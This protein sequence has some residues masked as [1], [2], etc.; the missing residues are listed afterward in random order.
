MK[1]I[2]YLFFIFAFVTLAFGSLKD[3]LGGLTMYQAGDGGFV[4]QQLR[5]SALQLA[6]GNIESTKSGVFLATVFNQIEKLTLHT[7]G[8]FIK[9]NTRKDGGFSD[10]SET[11]D[12]SSTRDILLIYNFLGIKVQN[13]QEILG[14]VRSLY[15]EKSGLY[16]N[17]V[18]E[19]GSLEATVSAFQVFNLLSTLKSSFVT[20]NF[21]RIQAILKEALTTVDR[22]TFFSFQ[23]KDLPAITANSYAAYLAVITELDITEHIEGLVNYFISLQKP[24]GG[25][26]SGDDSG[27]YKNTHEAIYAIALLSSV[28]KVDYITQRV[29]LEALQEFIESVGTSLTDVSYAQQTS[30]AAGLI[31]QHFNTEL[32]LENEQGDVITGGLTV[33]TRFRPTLRI[34]GYNGLASNRFT[35]EINTL[36]GANKEKFQLNYSKEKSKYI[37]IDIFDTRKDL[38]E[39]KFQVISRY[40]VANIGIIGLDFGASRTVGYKL[41]ISPKAYQESAGK[42][43]NVGE[44]VSVGTSFT[45]EVSLD[46]EK[47][48]E[49]FAAQMSVVDS[50]GAV[51]QVEE[52][53]TETDSVTFRFNLEKEN[54]PSGSLSFHFVVSNDKV[55]AHSRG[56]VVYQVSSKM[57]ASE[58]TFLGA[59]RKSVYK[60]GDRVDVRMVPASFD[61]RSV[62]LLDNTDFLGKNIS[63]E[64]FMDVVAGG[65]TVHSIR[66]H[67]TTEGYLFSLS[68][69]PKLDNFGHNTISFRYVTSTGESIELSPYDSE[70]NDL[71]DDVNQLS[72]SVPSDLRLFELTEEPKTTTLSY[73]NNVEFRFKLRD[74]N[75]GQI[76]KAGTGGSNV[77]LSLV[78]KDES[79]GNT[80]TS[81][82]KSATQSGDSFEIDWAITPNAISGPAE[83]VIYAQGINNQRLE[84]LS[85]KG[86]AVSYKVEIGGKID[87]SQNVYSSSTPEA[88]KTTVVATFSLS[89]Q[90]VDLRDALLYASFQTSDGTVLVPH[91]NVASFGSSYQV[92]LS[93]PHNNLPEGTYQFNFYPDLSRSTNQQ[94]S[95]THET[96]LFTVSLDHQGSSSSSLPFSPQ[97]FI[98]SIILAGFV[99]VFLKR[100]KILERPN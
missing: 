2:I 62:H 65:S 26:S 78:H 19:S 89:C 9:E 43:I 48:V 71:F 31:N 59:S 32:V 12:I 34:T 45:F 60:I 73:G 84:I 21:P 55:G 1:N 39:I 93:F 10:N 77:Y 76:I 35:V 40:Q 20:K 94:S 46:S 98:S 80:F 49:K 51:I 37:P 23:N 54:I 90:G 72:F 47:A 79:S 22:E 6:K 16:A 69:V 15:D 42:D 13:P 27:N 74:Q 92:S 14:F 99:A 58:I 91:V 68:L 97:L 83:I 25:F 67:Q 29:N 36:F 61:L 64:Y 70:N 18:G 38:G 66:G 17:S 44:T 88:D 63:R 53:T 3:T 86:Q 30:I 81:V 57:V 4:E 100:N 5:P 33:G 24:S 8:E 75:S 50:S 85:E 56:E 96:L 7:I 28:S 87:V 41:K 82:S 11:S 95:S 52:S